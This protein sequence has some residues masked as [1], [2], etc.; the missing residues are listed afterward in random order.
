MT[1][2]DSQQQHVPESQPVGTGQPNVGYI[3]TCM[4]LV[5]E[6]LRNAGEP[7]SSED[8]C[9]YCFSEGRAR[10]NIKAHFQITRKILV[11]LATTRKVQSLLDDNQ[12]FY[13]KRWELTPAY[14]KELEDKS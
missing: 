13:N 8:V 2:T 14:R 11:Y 7:V 5:L 4:G 12:K 1:S 3:D 10:H 6:C 9:T